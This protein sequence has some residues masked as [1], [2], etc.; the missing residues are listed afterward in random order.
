[1]SGAGQRLFLNALPQI[2]NPTL[3]LDFLGRDMNIITKILEDLVWKE[4]K[5]S[6]S[7]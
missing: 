6:F 1:M 5:I 7:C 2:T 4:P 3:R